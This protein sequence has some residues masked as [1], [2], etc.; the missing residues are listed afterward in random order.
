MS[1]PFMISPLIKDIAAIKTE[2]CV[3]VTS[4]YNVKLSE[5]PLILKIPMPATTSETTIET[6][7]GKAL[8]FGE[9]NS[10]IWRTTRLSGRQQTD[11]MIAVK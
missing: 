11:A 8:Y 6:S 2:I 10:V 3:S 7:M 9:Q 4:N 5:N 1:M